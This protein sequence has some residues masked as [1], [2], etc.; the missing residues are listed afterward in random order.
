MN[1]AA[2]SLVDMLSEARSSS[3]LDKIRLIQYLAQELERS[4]DNLLEPGL[5][6]AI[7]SPDS[8]FSAAGAFL[9]ALEDESGCTSHG[10]E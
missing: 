6:Y 1:G 9:L 3:R 8:A 5:S 2:M 10:R 7:W 4:E